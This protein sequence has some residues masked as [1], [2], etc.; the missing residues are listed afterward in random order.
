MGG[1]EG[2]AGPLYLLTAP[3]PAATGGAARVLPRSHQQF[4]LLLL[5]ALF[6]DAEACLLARV[7]CFVEGV[8]ALLQIERTAFLFVAECLQTVSN[9]RVIAG[10]RR[11]LRIRQLPQLGENLIA[12]LLM[13][14]SHFLERL[15]SGH[16]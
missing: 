9:R 7:E 6:E 16:E 4:E 8:V 15:Q 13:T 11:R 5:H 12:C 14:A 2:A 1:P 10:R 3:A